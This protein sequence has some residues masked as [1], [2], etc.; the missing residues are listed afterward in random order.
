MK[1]KNKSTNEVVTLIK[2]NEKFQTVM[3]EFEES[4]KVISITYA[5][6]H[7]DWEEMNE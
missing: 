5:T 6:L 3:L 4:K 7:K 1:Y 2:D